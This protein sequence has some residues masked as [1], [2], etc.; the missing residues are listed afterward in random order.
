MDKLNM[1]QF[2]SNQILQSA[3]TSIVHTVPSFNT[4]Y[5]YSYDIV[6]TQIF[7]ILFNT[8]LRVGT[9]VQQDSILKPRQTGHTTQFILFHLERL[10]LSVSCTIDYSVPNLSLSLSHTHTHT[11]N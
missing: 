2:T 1:L 10:K 5:T 6:S 3:L 9:T 8:T 4:H 7:L 11:Q